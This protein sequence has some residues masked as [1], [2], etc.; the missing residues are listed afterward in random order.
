MQ[1]RD[2]QSEVADFAEG[3]RLDRMPVSGGAKSSNSAARRRP[4]GPSFGP[5]LVK[6][7]AGST[8]IATHP[9]FG[10]APL[11]GA[12]T[13][14]R[15]LAQVIPISASTT[16]RPVDPREYRILGAMALLGPAIWLCHAALVWLRLL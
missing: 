6:G 8:A 10:D 3:R 13:R 1:K 15:P 4:A 16:P 9:S 7:F 5:V 11:R 12:E 14:M 2:H